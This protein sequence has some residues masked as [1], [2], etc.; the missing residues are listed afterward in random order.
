M[1]MK[2]ILLFA[3]LALSACAARREEERQ[4]RLAQ[5]RAESDARLAKHK[6]EMK[7]IEEQYAPK[8]QTS[9]DKAK[10]DREC[11]LYYAGLVKS[12]KSLDDNVSP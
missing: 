3:V 7:K 2:L 1:K 12:I 6:I 8:V 11:Y 9:E 5:Y 10:A 4:A